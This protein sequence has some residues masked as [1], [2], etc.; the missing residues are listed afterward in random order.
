MFKKTLLTTATIA[1]LSSSVMAE[2]LSVRQQ[3]WEGIK[4]GF[5]TS[6]DATVDGAKYISGKTVDGAKYV[7][8]KSVDGANAVDDFTQPAQDAVVNGAK[9]AGFAVANGA[10]ATANGIDYTFNMTTGIWKAGL[11]EMKGFEKIGGGIA[12]I[13]LT[14]VMFTIDVLDLVWDGSKEVYKGGKVVAKEIVKG[15]KAAVN[16]V[17]GVMSDDDKH[18]M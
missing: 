9:V 5:S 11:G 13:A 14:P 1:L 2:E 17:D 6:V 16:L 12:A 7:G 3:A 10:V 15:G 8:G 18:G 4:S